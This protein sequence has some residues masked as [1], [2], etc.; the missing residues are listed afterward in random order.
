MHHVSTWT[1]AREVELTKLS[2]SEFDEAR[3]MLWNSFETTFLPGAEIVAD[4]R[5]PR[6]L[7][8]VASQLPTNTQ[9]Q[10]RQMQCGEESVT[11]VTVPPI[12]TLHMLER[13]SSIFGADP[14]LK[15]YQLAGTWQAPCPASSRM[16]R[17]QRRLALE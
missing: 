5:L 13:A 3:K 9:R 11:A 8:I 17:K 10:F 16:L 15:G 6:A 14:Q 2:E 1:L 7:R 12:P 4:L